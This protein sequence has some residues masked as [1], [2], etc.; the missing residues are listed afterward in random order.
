VCFVW[1]V[2]WCCVEEG[3]VFSH[4]AGNV[5]IGTSGLLALAGAFSHLSAL[6]YLEL[7]GDY[8]IRFLFLFGW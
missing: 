7:N 2:I 6:Q 1:V 3:H 8:F 5:G 4:A